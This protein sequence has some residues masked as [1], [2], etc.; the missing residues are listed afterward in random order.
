LY[1]INGRGVQLFAAPYASRASLDGTI[2]PAPAAAG[3][4][5]LR[6]WTGQDAP[7]DSGAQVNT[8]PFLL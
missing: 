2:E 8:L 7:N 5:A 6:E 3:D 4:A 1:A